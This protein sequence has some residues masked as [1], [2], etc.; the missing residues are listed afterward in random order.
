M[1]LA[2][3]ASLSLGATAMAA[4]IDPA[5]APRASESDA[6]GLVTRQGHGKSWAGTNNYFLQALSDADQQIYVAELVAK[7]IKV[8]RL[9][10]NGH[11]AGCEKGSLRVHALPELEEQI[12]QFNNATLDAVDKT[13]ALLWQNNI[14]VILSP[15][16]GNLIYGI[17]GK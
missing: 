5:M 15:H 14:K 17:G 10:I 13:I 3:L 11:V 12:G 16:N 8:V 6:G 1:K 9:F 4:A 2:L 7:G